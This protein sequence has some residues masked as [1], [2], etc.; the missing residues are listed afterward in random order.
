ML[1]YARFA[2]TFVA[3]LP[4]LVVHTIRAQSLYGSLVGHVTDP[5]GATVPGAGVKIIHLETQQVRGTRTNIDGYYSFPAIPPGTYELE[6]SRDGFQTFMQR[7]IPVSINSIVRVD[8]S[9]VIGTTAESVEVTDRTPLLQTDR[10]EVRSDF[11]T[12]SLTN[13]PLPPGRNY[14]LLFV[15]IPGFTP[16]CELGPASDQSFPRYNRPR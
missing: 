15:T 10:A 4:L 11:T 1:P 14:E 8:A 13:L 3:I 16:P 7:K 5:A 9:L 12:H 2:A 6:I